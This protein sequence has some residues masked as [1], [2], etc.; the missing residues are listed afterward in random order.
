MPFRNRRIRFTLLALAVAVTGLS[1]AGPAVAATPPPAT[2]QTRETEPPTDF[3]DLAPSPLRAEGSRHFTV[4]YRNSGTTT[5]MVAPQLLLLSPDAGPYLTPA[6]LTVERRTG[7]GC[8]VPVE[9]GSQTGTLYTDLTGAQRRLDAGETLTERYR[10]T[11]A[12]PAARGV[13]QPRVALYG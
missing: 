10:V 6:D 4:T 13:V 11:V 5:V 12:N 8:W 3:V 7:H 1:A 9:L 2:S